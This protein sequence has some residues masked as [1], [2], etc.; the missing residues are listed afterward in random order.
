M[1]TYLEVAAK[2]ISKESDI[3]C[4]WIIVVFALMSV[5]YKIIICPH[6]GICVRQATLRGKSVRWEHYCDIKVDGSVFNKTLGLERGIF[7]GGG[8]MGNRDTDGKIR[9]NNS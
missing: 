4:E 2:E 5:V 7:K 1:K 9:S 3:K 8:G 6:P